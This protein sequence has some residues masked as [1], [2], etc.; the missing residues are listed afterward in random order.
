MKIII[1]EDAALSDKEREEIKDFITLCF[2]KWEED[3]RKLLYFT[4]TFHH[5]FMYEGNTL[6]SYL[7]III[8]KIKWNGKDIIIGGVGDVSTLH[9]FRGKGYATELVKKGI[10]LLKQE[11]A[12]I[13][14]LQTDTRKGAKLYKEAGFIPA[15]KSYTFQDAKGHI[16]NQWKQAVMLAPISNYNLFH[17]IVQSKKQLFIG[18]GDW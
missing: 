18:K 12:D 14:L 9:D 7:R 8:R 4:P 13:G 16:R 3:K 1:K 6:V 11:G 10:A 15:N 17:E 2:G 5:L